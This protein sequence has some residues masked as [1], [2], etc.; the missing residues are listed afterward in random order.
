MTG[1]FLRSI[2]GHFFNLLP[3]YVSRLSHYEAL[4]SKFAPQSDDGGRAGGRTTIYLGRQNATLHY[5]FKVQ[6]AAGL[7]SVGALGGKNRAHS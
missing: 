4:L 1:R 3:H 6:S 5:Q 7:V 2:W